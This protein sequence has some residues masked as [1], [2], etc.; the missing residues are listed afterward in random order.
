MGFPTFLHIFRQVW[1]YR[2]SQDPGRQRGIRWLLAVNIKT[3]CII[4][5]FYNVIIILFQRYNAFFM[6][7]FL[8][9]C[10]K[11][12][13][14]RHGHN[15]WTWF[16]DSGCR[17]LN[18]GGHVKVELPE[19]L[20]MVSRIHL[21]NICCEYRGTVCMSSS[22]W[23]KFYMHQQSLVDLISNASHK[24]FISKNIDHTA[25]CSMPLMAAVAYAQMLRLTPGSCILSSSSSTQQ[26]ASDTCFNFRM[27]HVKQKVSPKT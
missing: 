8:P 23:R 6:E 17:W 2:S 25:I 13:D 16:N 1:Q 7:Y 22:F 10:R 19:H 14:S 21:W 3:D 11:N 12:V 24:F 26:V 15:G 5:Y 4:C 18:M 20:R 9:T 27:A